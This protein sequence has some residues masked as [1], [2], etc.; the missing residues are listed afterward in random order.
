MHKFTR[1][2]ASSVTLHRL[3]TKDYLFDHKEKQTKG[4]MCISVDCC[5]QESL[6]PEC[7]VIAAVEIV[8]GG[9]TFILGIIYEYGNVPVFIGRGDTCK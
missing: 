5:C 7:K 2:D 3:K 1:N 8:L 9:I 6:K 4:D